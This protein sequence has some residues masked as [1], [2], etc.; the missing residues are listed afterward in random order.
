MN[1]TVHVRKEVDGDVS[2]HALLIAEKEDVFQFGKRRLSTAKM[3]SSMTWC[4][5]TLE[6]CE[7]G[8]TRYV[9]SN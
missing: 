2:A 7:I 1:V 8:W 6:S 3:I 5:R 9:L 4:C